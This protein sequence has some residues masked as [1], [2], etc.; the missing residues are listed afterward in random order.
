MDNIKKSIEIKFENLISE[1]RSENIS[2]AD[3]KLIF[4]N[5]FKSLKSVED[6]SKK[7]KSKKQSYLRPAL[8]ISDSSN[9][10]S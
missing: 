4:N 1:A 8:W 10:E 9:D 3:I 2:L 7:R 6:R 5:K